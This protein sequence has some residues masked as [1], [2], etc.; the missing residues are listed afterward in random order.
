MVE[1]NPF[2]LT[3]V[4]LAIKKNYGFNFLPLGK[5]EIKKLVKNCL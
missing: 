5:I 1:K 4:E 3:K 2:D